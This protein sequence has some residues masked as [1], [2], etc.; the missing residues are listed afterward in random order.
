MEEVI[1]YI[2]LL[3]SQ[4][5]INFSIY[6]NPKAYGRAIFIVENEFSI[7]GMI[8]DGNK[9]TA[10]VT[11]EDPKNCVVMYNNLRGLLKDSM[12]LFRNLTAEDLFSDYNYM[13]SLMTENQSW[14]IGH[15]TELLLGDEVFEKVLTRM[16]KDIPVFA[17]FEEKIRTL[18][19]IMQ[20]VITNTNIRILF[21]DSVFSYLAFSDEIDFYGYKVR[22]S[23]EDKL[24]ILDYS[25]K[26]L[27]END[28]LNIKMA[29]GKFDER[30]Y[31]ANQSIFLSDRA[32]YL[33]LNNNSHQSRIYQ[34]DQ[35]DI[36]K[37]SLDAFDSIWENT[38]GVLTT[39]KEEILAHIRQVA[40]VI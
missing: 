20:R 34:T 1:F 14:M 6:R 37:L 4:M 23:R 28:N 33:R 39:D 2:R 15:V 40:R 36:Q 5:H 19:K 30:F 8:D 29:F 26:F 11:S 12:M 3:V 13:H 24:S 38:Q 21:C 18:H 27:E 35:A 7:S 25:K 32:S 22:I 10:V 9:C 31:I 17:L 16:I